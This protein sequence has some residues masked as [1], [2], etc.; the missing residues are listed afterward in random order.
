[1]GDI[2]RVPMRVYH[3]KNKWVYI[4]FSRLFKKRVRHKANK[5]RDIKWDNK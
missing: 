3:I 5:I 4:I 1:M 2:I